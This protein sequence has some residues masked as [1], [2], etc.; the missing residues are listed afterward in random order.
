MVNELLGCEFVLS[1]KSEKETFHAIL[2]NVVGEELDY[3]LITE[4]ND[5]IS[6]LVD[7]SA[8]ET[9]AATIGKEELSSILWQ[10]GVSQEKLEHL[11]QIFENAMGEKPLTAVNLIERKTVLSTSSITVNIGR[12][13]TD[14]VRCENI[15][16][17]RC[18]VIDLDDPEVSVNGIPTNLK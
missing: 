6:E 9:E 7:Q 1:F 14:K 2:N 18:L 16:G 3:D 8:H 10:S 12:D 11:P 15:D 13:A 5:R 4:V 17:R